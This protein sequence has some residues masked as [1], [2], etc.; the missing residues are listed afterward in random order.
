[1]CV[2]SWKITRVLKFQNFTGGRI[3]FTRAPFYIPGNIYYTCSVTKL[4]GKIGKCILYSVTGVAQNNHYYVFAFYATNYVFLGN[5]V[6]FFPPR[7]MRWSMKR[8]A[9]YQIL[10]GR[11]C[12]NEW[13][14]KK[15]NNNNKKKTRFR[16]RIAFFDFGSL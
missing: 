9:F 4:I 3:A 7:E 13:T 16:V 11:R 5:F 1:M 6:S 10:V 14:I 2:M 12:K 8:N 15:N